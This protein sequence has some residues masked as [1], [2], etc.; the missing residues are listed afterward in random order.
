MDD[1]THLYTSSVQGPQGEQGP[2]GPQ[3]PAGNIETFN[4]TTVNEFYNK[5]NELKNR[6]LKVIIDFGGTTFSGNVIT[7]NANDNTISSRTFSVGLN[8]LNEMVEFIPI[9]SYN[10]S[11][12]EII[13]TK[14][15]TGG[16][17]R[18]EISPYIVSMTFS[19]TTQIRLVPIYEN[20]SNSAGI[21]ELY[22]GGYQTKN[23][24]TGTIYYI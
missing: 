14:F 22:G 6:V 3:G 4:F 9:H 1:D 18:F 19:S 11:T 23:S 2:Q 10:N 8:S 20:I 16:R 7:I 17:P 12:G 5:I 15:I 24:A 13:D 21:I